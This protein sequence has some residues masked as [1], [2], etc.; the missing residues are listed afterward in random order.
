VEAI[1]HRSP[2]RRLG[3]GISSQQHSPFVDREEA[4]YL[5]TLGDRV[6]ADLVVLKQVIDLVSAASFEDTHRNRIRARRALLGALVD[7]AE[8]QALS[9]PAPAFRKAATPLHIVRSRR[10][11]EVEGVEDIRSVPM[12][13][14]VMGVA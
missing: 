12:P 8:V 1:V 14:L 6:A 2:G 11:A 4:E 5:N 7:L 13:A 10:G 9:A 3:S